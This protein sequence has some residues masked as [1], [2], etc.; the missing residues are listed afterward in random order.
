MPTA[1]QE[2]YVTTR[3]GIVYVAGGILADGLTFTDAFEAYDSAADTWAVL[4]PL[5]APRHHI[6]TAAVGT[7]IYAV[8]GFVGPFPDWRALPDT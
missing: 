3:D 6:T 4:A 8:G 1:R 5:P 7:K 2:V